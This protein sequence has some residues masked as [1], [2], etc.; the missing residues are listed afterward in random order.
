MVKPS[1]LVPLLDDMESART[2]SRRFFWSTGWEVESFAVGRAPPAGPLKVV[3]KVSGKEEAP[4]V[5]PI[6]H[7]LEGN[8]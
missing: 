6:R 3:L 7:K 8:G 4:W 2:A 1:Q 5:V